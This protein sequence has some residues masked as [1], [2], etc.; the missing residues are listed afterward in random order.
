MFMCVYI[1]LVKYVNDSSP[2][3]SESP[4]T[5]VNMRT[6]VCTRMP[7]VILNVLTYKCLSITE[8][9]KKRSTNR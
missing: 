3:N 1:D 9:Y 2:V 6:N 4:R 5:Y 7:K 8:F